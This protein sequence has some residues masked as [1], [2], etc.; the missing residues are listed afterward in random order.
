MDYKRFPDAM[1]SRTAHLSQ[2]TKTFNELERLMLSSENYDKVHEIYNKLCEK[3]EHFKAAHILCIDMCEDT[4][5]LNSMESNFTS[6]V[7]NIAEFSE[8]YSEWKKSV[9]NTE[10][11][12]SVNSRVTV[13]NNSS[14]RSSRSEML[15]AKARKL[16]AE[17]KLKTLIEKQR[18]DKQQRK[19]QR[20]REELEERKQLLD[21]QSEIDQAQVEEAVW[22]QDAM[23]PAPVVTTDIPQTNTATHINS[24]SRTDDIHMT[25]VVHSQ[26]PDVMLNKE[27]SR[28]ARSIEYNEERLNAANDHLYNRREVSGNQVPVS[29][30][31]MDTSD[32]TVSYRTNTKG[33]VTSDISSIDTAFNRL[34]STLQE[35]FNLPKPELL[36]FTGSAIDYCK[37]IKNF[38]TNIE[39]KILDNRLRLSYLIQYCTGEAKSCIEDCVLLESD[40]GYARA[41]E[42]L[43]TR[44]GKPHVIARFYIEKISLW[45]TN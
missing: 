1:K 42:I 10:D 9:N 18:I 38:E 19:L 16:V 13:T 36:T 5:K 27:V 24:G 25:T 40:V 7:K 39:S 29:D 37:F 20:E 4:E 2:L 26:I 44:Y 31:S 11:C 34:A 32:T 14:V 21:V 22:Q 12:I 3:Y 23:F 6:Q 43:K 41:R 8:R 17:Q 35:G 30:V 15:S 33:K 45:T 28:S